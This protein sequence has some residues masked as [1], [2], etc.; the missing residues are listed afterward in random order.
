MG[1]LPMLKVVAFLVRVKEAITM[2]DEEF[3]FGKNKVAMR[4]CIKDLH[5]KKQEENVEG[6]K[7]LF[8]GKPSDN[9]ASV[10]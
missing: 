6:E 9:Q 1:L 2:K 7:W 10:D 3:F 5:M 4:N 8:I